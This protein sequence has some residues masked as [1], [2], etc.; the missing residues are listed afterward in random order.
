[1]SSE[2]RGDVSDQQD[3]E[4][5]AI[6][7]AFYRPNGALPGTMNVDG[8][9]FINE[10]LKHFD[11]DFFGINNLEAT[12]MDP[13]QRKLLEVV[14]ECFEDAGA[15]LEDLSKS[16]IGCFVANF[17]S[18]F[19]LI[20]SK[21][22]DYA[23]R[24]TATGL[25]PTILSNRISHVF[26]LRG[27]SLTLDTA[28]SSSLYCLH[29]ACRA[30]QHLE[31]SGAI[32][33]GTNLILT[34]EQFITT[35]KAG[36]LSPT[37]TCHP[38]SKDADG[39]GRAEGLGA[40]Y[41]KRLS[42]AIRD[43]DNVRSV[44]RGTAVNSNGRTSGITL[45][46]S[47]GQEEV[48]RQAY[49]VA[50]L[51]PSDTDYVECHGT[52]T[53][54]GDPTEIEAL[55]R[56]FPQVRKSA[57]DYH[58]L[59][60]GSVKS[61]LG[62][63]EATSGITSIIKATLA[64]ERRTIPATIGIQELN[65]KIPW[66]DM[67]LE[68]V[69]Q[70]TPWP[71]REDDK[72]VPRASVNSFGYGGSNGHCIL[73]AF[74]LLS[75]Q[76]QADDY[77][78]TRHHLLPVSAATEKALQLR[79][80]DLLLADAAQMNSRDLAYTLG[81]RRSQLP[82]RSFLIAD[83]EQMT[84]ELQKQQWRSRVRTKDNHHVPYTFVFT[85]Q[86][87]QWPGMGKELFEHH[88]AFQ[89]SIKAL[90]AVLRQLPASPSW[91]LVE[92]M[93]QPSGSRCLDD[94]AVAQPLCT[95]I[96]IA[97]VDLLREWNICPSNVIGHS[98]GEIA[99]AY[100]AGHVSAPYAIAI[101]YFRGQV[102]S[103]KCPEG[104]M[105]AVDASP[106]EATQEISMMALSSHMRVACVN[107]PSSVTISGDAFAIR[108]LRAH[109]ESKGRF[110][111]ELR[112]GSRAYHSHHM[113]SCGERYERILHDIEPLRT[114]C[115]SAPEAAILNPAAMI[116]TVTAGL[117]HAVQTSK[118]EYW[119]Q[120]LESPVLFSQAFET[121]R[122]RNAL[123]LIEVGPH[124]ALKR[125]ATQILNQLDLTGQARP[126]LSV[127][128][129]DHD[130][131]Q[132]ALM[133]A[134][135]L[136]TF[137]HDVSLGKVNQTSITT[138][139]RG[140]QN[141]RP[142]A[143][144]TLP[145]YRWDYTA[146]LWDEGL[147]SRDFRNRRHT[148]D[149]LL[150]AR[151]PGANGYASVWYNRLSLGNAPWI[152]D[153]KLGNDVIFPAAAYVS[154]ACR[155]AE[156]LSTSI[157]H[158]K[159]MELHQISFQKALILSDREIELFTELLPK[160]DSP[161][162]D[163]EKAW[164]FTI[165]SLN[166]D[167]YVQRARGFV[168]STAGALSPRV[169]PVTAKNVEHQRAQDWYKRFSRVG[170]AFGP[171][172]QNLCTVYSPRM[173]DVQATVATL[174]EPGP[175]NQNVLL[176][177][178]PEYNPLII[179][180]MLQAGIIA[181][182]G[183]EFEKLQALVPTKIGHI[184]IERNMRHAALSKCEIHSS[185]KCLGS[186]DIEI[187]S[188]L[189]DSRG[190][191]MMHLGDIHAMPITG[192]GMSQQNRHPMLRIDW[193][194]DM[195]KLRREDGSA[196]AGYL[197]NKVA[198][199]SSEPLFDRYAAIILELMAHN[200]SG[201]RVLDFSMANSSW[202][203]LALTALHADSR[204]RRAQVY[205]QAHVDAEGRIL[206]S[207][208]ELSGQ[209]QLQNGVPE[210]DIG[211]SQFDVICTVD[212]PEAHT[213]L[214]EDLRA[215]VKYLAPGGVLISRP[216]IQILEGSTLEG[217]CLPFEDIREN[218]VLAR[219]H[220][221]CSEAD[222]KTR[223]ATPMCLVVTDASPSPLDK[224]LVV[225]ISNR[226]GCVAE[227][228]PIHDLDAKTFPKGAIMIVT[229]E[230]TENILLKTSEKQWRHLRR[231]ILASSKIV[232]VVSGDFTIAQ[233]P[234]GSL[235]LG[236]SR[237]IAIEEP[238]IDFST[239]FVDETV[240][241]T[242]IAAN[243]CKILDDMDAEFSDRE[244]VQKQNMLYVSRFI[245]D[246]GQNEQFFRQKTKS[247][248][249][250]TLSELDFG[251]LVFKRE[252]LTES[253]GFDRRQRNEAIAIAEDEVE[254][255]VKSIGLNTEIQPVPAESTTFASPTSLVE[256]AGNVERVGSMVSGIEVGDKVVAIAPKP[257][258]TRIRTPFWTCWKLAY[259]ENF[260]DVTSTPLAYMTAATALTSIAKL[261]SQESI[262]IH[263][264]MSD[265]GMAAIQHGRREIGAKVYTT[266]ATKAEEDFLTDHL[267][268]PRTS[269][270]NICDEAFPEK[271]FEAISDSGVDVVLDSS[272][273]P[274]RQVLHKLVS[275]CRKFAR[276][277]SV[278]RPEPHHSDILNVYGSGKALTTTAFKLQDYYP[279]SSSGQSS[280]QRLLSQSIDSHRKNTL[281][282]K[283]IFSAAN[284]GADK[285]E[286]RQLVKDLCASGAQVD[287]VRGNVSEYKVVEEAL[288]RMSL[289]LGG[290]IQSAMGLG[291]ATF[292]EMTLKQWQISLAPKV[293]G[294]VNL[295]RAIQNKDAELD[296]FLMI[297]SVSGTIGH[298]TEGNYCAAN[299]FLDAFARHRR[300]LG[301]PAMSIGFG[302]VTEIGY[303]HDHPNIEAMMNRKGVS[304]VTEDD[305]LVMCDI[306]LRDQ[307]NGTGK[308]Q[309]WDGH[310]LSGLENF[311]KN[312]T[313]R[314][315]FLGSHEDVVSDPR[316]CVMAQA[317][318]KIDNGTAID[319]KS[320]A[321]AN[322]TAAIASKQV[323]RLE[324]LMYAAI[325][326]RFSHMTANP[327]EK[328]SSN[329]KLLNVGM[330]SM[331]AA[332]FRTSMFKL[333]KVEVPFFR[334]LDADM[335]IQGLVEE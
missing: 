110:A 47:S 291:E 8:G 39:Y 111:R 164:E 220:P 258:D 27:P 326:E 96:Q 74:H 194:P 88:L 259:H 43:G 329:L 36:V 149:Q 207:N 284:I 2:A 196:L 63:S 90:D 129:R 170:Q 166:G 289:P 229:I 315:G 58:P 223:L 159:R 276:F 37:S 188:D 228:V 168:R 230:V 41:L 103:F 191:S 127:L 116:S 189:L 299:A 59:L 173:R 6:I 71:H 303:L 270:F 181:S 151:I 73:E 187:R 134:G 183:G 253:F 255:S 163:G 202:T 50:S 147:T 320:T 199:W 137:G 57:G 31:C 273:S 219:R 180:A 283:R 104:A 250:V 70:N 293:T 17:T 11:N 84:V 117:V 244:Y 28:C 136:W 182:A 263:P 218:I 332:E 290:I 131:V 153:H 215:I 144:T 4:P 226:Y 98:S 277:V 97:L 269:F 101:A 89:N 165:G 217:V 176:L 286:A 115:S 158:A 282:Q 317:L 297:S 92:Q 77:H 30:I 275:V 128:N 203:R 256:F 260:N 54:T 169:L 1:M 239:L 120:N 209:P 334:L 261:S 162:K 204:F 201:V 113:L 91:T 227:T 20:Q 268:L 212:S 53:A 24:Y 69:R 61:G 296:F 161:F 248:S 19:Q 160:E 330:D 316:F 174:V 306:A 152:E 213:L 186:A 216:G 22:A 192:L 21:N 32:V 35:A 148:H 274:S 197:R 12:S 314:Q 288:G 333:C 234:G 211:E 146:P 301:Q 7:A 321:Q 179:D 327:V 214:K 76:R 307:S 322:I 79:F 221:E 236:L 102:L 157:P 302:P 138:S 118:P 271:L 107:S 313:R 251:S 78:K 121:L 55:V 108:K 33:A 124:P 135:T 224:Q 122:G 133:L 38:F 150:G 240:N 266:I 264:G 233:N 267:G 9:Y 56:A 112:T 241:A 252:G 298:A 237:T 205:T 265:V 171:A 198:T 195:K 44:I 72:Y 119:R 114:L 83:Q 3:F 200:K 178:K 312:T 254:I 85:G 308:V 175:D 82:V 300:H 109:M 281:L 51:D 272:A 287:I 142:C 331:M 141:E 13:Q 81:E 25:G 328:L 68:V 222:T 167:R 52:G 245:P 105:M 294:T 45:P 60:V 225:E 130:S 210:Q 184:S 40:L 46:S 140:L 238:T 190:S 309:S 100:S 48:I 16:Q 242:S 235:V 14:Y 154:M 5:I 280:W 93:T 145:K 295:H 324:S 231:A 156:Q 257:L 246:D 15:R 49:A 325:V 34:P 232:W 132:T 75:M 172:F 64:L 311:N 323:S 66:R 247:P 67:N 26:N 262:L 65:P 123:Q 335:T 278:G 279:E 185:A 80:D 310:I 143:L 94:P 319:D 208:L 193:I 87:A 62:H 10:D 18:D 292:R 304:P 243:V 125:P 86:G 99:A 206:G 95:A 139:K 42:D 23:H 285:P 318:Q 126:Y 177:P 29:L 249:N 305:V 155:A 106:K